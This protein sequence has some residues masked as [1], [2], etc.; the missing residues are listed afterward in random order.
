MSTRSHRFILMFA[1][2]ASLIL[3]AVV[4]MP[5]IVAAAMSEAQYT[6]LDE[7]M[8]EEHSVPEEEPE[9]LG[10]DESDVSTMTWVGYDTYQEHLAQLSDFDQAQFIEASSPVSASTQGE[11]PGP[12]AQ[13][14]AA[15]QPAATTTTTSSGGGGPIEGRGDGDGGQPSTDTGPLSAQEPGPATTPAEQPSEQPEE[16]K[17]TAQPEPKPAPE[18]P[19]GDAPDAGGG[20]PPSNP[21]DEPTPPAPDASKK[22]S[23]ATS[24]ISVPRDKWLSGRPLASQG[25]ELIPKRPNLTS[26]QNLNG[27]PNMLVVIKFGA[28]GKPKDAE[29]LS[30]SGNIGVD[31]A[32][33]ASLYRWRA[34][35]K[36]LNGL[37]ETGTID[38]RL[39][40]ISRRRR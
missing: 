13:A 7:A 21:S 37:T 3:H 2:I 40:L 36:R 35:G 12:R 26:L 34:R 1:V 22:E 10:L 18:T 24:T 16:P 15:Q 9:R 30:S 27:V 11:Q 8:E 17:D 38:V 25:L 14:G 28:N 29:I 6:D 32:V 19:P 20:A 31:V 4:L 39:E 33:K 5:S 23:D